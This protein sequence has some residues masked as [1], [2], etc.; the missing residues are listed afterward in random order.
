M[1]LFSGRPA[2]EVVIEGTLRREP[3]ETR[4]ESNP[5]IIEGHQE[6]SPP[7][8]PIARYSSL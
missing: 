4:G 5:L 2:I 6:T 3:P 1:N 8:Q 7:P